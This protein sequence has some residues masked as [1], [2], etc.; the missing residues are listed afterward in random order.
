[1]I[2]LKQ[3]LAEISKKEFNDIASTYQNKLSEDDIL[4]LRSWTV[5]L[6]NPLK[7]SNLMTRFAARKYITQS[8][9]IKKVSQEFV[10][11]MF[12][13]NPIKIY[14]GIRNID[15]KTTHR[16]KSYTFNQGF[17]KSWGIKSTV[18]EKEITYKDVIGV[19]SI[20]FKNWYD[21]ESYDNEVEVIIDD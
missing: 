9:N 11:R 21:W 17:A 15:K 20:A 14:R 1:M 2:K 8:E 5:N 13:T 4:A 6:S 10:K 3:I 18:I 16:I 19:P 12:G 7:S